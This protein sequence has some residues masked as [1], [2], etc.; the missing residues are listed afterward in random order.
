MFRQVLAR[1]FGVDISCQS[2]EILRLQLEKVDKERRE[3]LTRLL[4]PEPSPLP[5]VKE[6]E[7][8]AITPP[9]VPW[10]VRQQMLESEDRRSAQIARD[11]SV[12]IEKLEA[13]MGLKD[14]I[15]K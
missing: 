3:L 9:F 12:E 6:E 8:V 5:P 15:Q 10:R 4:A 13:E 11:R 2:C 14:A 1:W 7:P